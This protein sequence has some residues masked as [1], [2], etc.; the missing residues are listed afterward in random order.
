MGM[1]VLTVAVALGLGWARPA[2]AEDT[3]PADSVVVE[4]TDTL[5]YS[6]NHVTV[7]VGGTVRWINPGSVPHTV[8]AD[9]AKAMDPSHVELPAR[10]RSFDSGDIG[11]GESWSRTFDVPGDYRY[12]CIPHERAGMVG[13]LTVVPRGEDPPARTSDVAAASEDEDGFHL[14]THVPARHEEMRSPD[15]T[16]MRL[17]SWLG[18]FHP[19]VVHFPIGLLVAAALA[20]LAVVFG[21]RTETTRPAAR[22]C[23]WLGV[24]TAILATVLGWLFAGFRIDDGAW[25]LTTHRWAGTALA[26]ASVVVLALGERAWRNPEHRGA[27]RRYRVGVFALAVLVLATGFV[28]AAM[29]YGLSAHAWPG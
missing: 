1:S 28:G 16:G 22:F 10:A 26:V 4:M 9:S 17:L 24:V 25:M 18:T 5:D 15:S 20:E 2:A 11:P 13:T 12:F 23:L 14:G 21:W 27:L 19:P 7:T 3:A 8:T 29:I 6:P